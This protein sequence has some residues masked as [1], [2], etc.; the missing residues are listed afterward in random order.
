[1]GGVVGIK[2]KILKCISGLEERFN[3]QNTIFTESGA[4][5]NTEIK[6]NHLPI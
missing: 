6:E 1:M 5:K 4:L 3:I 2:M